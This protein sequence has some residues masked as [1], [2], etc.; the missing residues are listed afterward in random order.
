L[1]ISEKALSNFVCFIISGANNVNAGL[2]KYVLF[3]FLHG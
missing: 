2:L 3:F 1:I